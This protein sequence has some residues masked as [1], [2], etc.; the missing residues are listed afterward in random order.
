MIQTATIRPGFLVSVK[1]TVSG[2][3]SYQRTDLEHDA[4]TD[5]KDVSRWETVRVIED[6]VEHERAVKAR[7]AALNAIRRLCSKT[8]FGLLCALDNAAALEAAVAEA[9]AIVNEFNAT[10][11]YTR[12]QI[13]ALKGKIA[14]TD[15]E[16]ARAIGQ[17]V[18]SLIADM[19]AGISKL[20]PKAIREAAN[21]AREMA[22]MLGEEA[23]G[24]VE[25]AIEQA[26]KAA[27]AIVKR[28]EKEGEAAAFVLADI[29]RGAIE[30]ARIAFLDLGE[31]AAPT[32]ALPAVDRQRFADLDLGDDDDEGEGEG[33]EGAGG[34]MA[35]GGG[36]VL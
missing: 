30:K 16:A 36:E 6:P 27:R 15:E 10:A 11:A 2:G 3:V 31:A 33:G 9:R 5:A 7:G 28:I 12:V 4:S 35:A 18:A 32:A 25:G 26:R 29:Q 24:K 17:E 34:A 14:S 20:D 21:K 1:S 13:Y 19:D 8:S 22:S 23:A